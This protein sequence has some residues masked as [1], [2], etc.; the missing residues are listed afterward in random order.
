MEVYDEGNGLQSDAI[1]LQ[2]V[3]TPDRNMGPGGQSLGTA[4]KWSNAKNGNETFP[5]DNG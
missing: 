2:Y 5:K 1:G 4:W 3:S